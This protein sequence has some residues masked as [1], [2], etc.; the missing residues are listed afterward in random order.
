MQQVRIMRLAD[1]EKLHFFPTNPFVGERGEYLVLL[2]IIVG[3]VI[4][5]T[6]LFDNIEK[7]RYANYLERM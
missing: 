1:S 2:I 4:G 7:I 6:I 5:S 3:E